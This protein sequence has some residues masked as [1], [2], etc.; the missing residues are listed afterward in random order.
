MTGSLRVHGPLLLVLASVVTT[1]M[2]LAKEHE[3]L[4]ATGPDALLF[5]L[6]C[7][8]CLALRC[9]PWSR[10]WRFA[11]DLA[12]YVGLF[13]AS[14][15]IGA[16]A[17]YPDAAASS[18]LVDPLLERGDRL[19]HFDWVGLY[20]LTSH[21]PLLQ[22]MGAIAYQSIY[23]IPAV[24]FIRFAW[25]GSRTEAHRFL[26]A[27]WLAAVATLVLFRWL[28]AAGPLALLWKGPLPYLPQ[29]ALYQ[30][31]LV[32]L[33]QHHRLRVVDV[34]ALHGL[35][36]APSFHAA[37]GVLFILFARHT[38]R[39]RVPLVGLSLLMLAATPI[40]GTH[41]LVDII[42]GVLVALGA[43]AATRLPQL[44][45]LWNATAMPGSGR[46]ATTQRERQRA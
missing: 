29:S 22:T 5:A 8:L 46:S 40:E 39:L 13:S 30:A 28:P 43:H 25:I 35:V 33:L 20:L 36:S 9:G 31:H 2:L 16:V 37:S 21:H 18:G 26:V 32:P 27:F 42:A 23:L 4:R 14:A 38:G 6:G 34:D 17:S 44:C 12:E 24:L 11:R 15:M 3:Q 41:Y 10:R 7:C 19:L 1:A 45:W